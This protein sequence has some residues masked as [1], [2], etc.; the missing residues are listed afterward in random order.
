MSKKHRIPAVTRGSAES[1]KKDVRKLQLVRERT[2][3]PPAAAGRPETHLY[4]K[5][6]DH[7]DSDLY[8]L[9]P[10]GFYT[11][12]QKGRICDL[13]EKAANLLSFPA[14]WLI[15]KSFVVFIAR[16]DAQRFL[17][18]LRSSV[19]LKQKTMEFDMYVADRTVPAQITVTTWTRG[20]EEF[21][22]LSIIDLSESR[23]TERL[24]EESLSNWYSLVHN[25]PDT[26]MT[27]EADGRICFV[28][29]PTWGY[30]VNAL[31]GTSLLD[32]TPKSGHA[33]VLRCLAQSFKLNKRS[34]CDLTGLCGDWS[35]WYSFSFGSPHP[36]ATVIPREGK[37]RRRT[38]TTTTTTTTTVMIR[39]IS[40][41]KRKEASLR[42]SGEQLREFAAR[43]EAVREEERAR[44]A[45]ELHDELGQSLTAL[46]LDLSWLHRK[47]TNGNRMK[48]K[49]MIVQVDETI[50][51]VRQISSQLRPPILDD[52]GLIPAMD[53]HVRDFQKRTG[54]QTEIVSNVDELNLSA[55]A[56]AAVYRVLQEAL[57]NV[58]RHA[59]ASRVCVTV[60]LA[61]R[62]L[63]IAIEDNGQGMTPTQ[64]ADLKSLGIVG[65]KERISRIGGAF[66][67]FSGP[68]KGTRLDILIPTHHD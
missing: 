12:D 19:E 30:S 9:S 36:V 60:D 32:H 55:E 1:R 21:H 26:I 44:L 53:W 46:K 28:N 17:K 66:Q 13:N 2:I 56:S 6:T 39:E 58:I 37:R 33:K 63:R 22:R 5:D 16:Q 38:T 23:N 35:S 54:I 18:F 64:G 51:K 25:A 10:I 67:I 62:S 48:M 27:V 20:R 14:N 3:S 59:K 50:D 49:T 7:L 41:H 31:V 29:R 24:L 68:G 52:L 61:G 4:H 15:G 65:M 11:L 40:E 8:H 45:R 43:L 34:V 42:L 57:T 47:S